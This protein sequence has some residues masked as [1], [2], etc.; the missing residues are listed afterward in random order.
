MQISVKIEENIAYPNNLCGQL[1]FDIKI[2]TTPNDSNRFTNKN[3]K[4]QTKNNKNEGEFLYPRQLFTYI[5]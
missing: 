4:Q 1:L 3:K 5:Q 2:P